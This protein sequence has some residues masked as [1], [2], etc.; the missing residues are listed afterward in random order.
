MKK[1][2]LATAV[3]LTMGVSATA[4]TDSDIRAT[5]PHTVIYSQSLANDFTGRIFV[6]DDSGDVL[7]SVKESETYLAESED[8]DGVRYELEIDLPGTEVFGVKS[9][10]NR[11]VQVDNIEDYISD[12][13]P[14][15]DLVSDDDNPEDPYAEVG[16]VIQERVVMNG[17]V[18]SVFINEYAHLAFNQELAFQSW[19]LFDNDFPEGSDIFGDDWTGVVPQED[20]DAFMASSFAVDLS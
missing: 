10:G 6:A 13:S 3:A 5:G 4:M 15:M 1:V 9:L 14:I 12:S 16:V 2:I 7:L 17:N 18:A 19:D 20:Y 11:Y 8:L